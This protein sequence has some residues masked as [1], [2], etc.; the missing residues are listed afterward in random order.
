M[1]LHV[2]TDRYVGRDIT[3]CRGHSVPEDM[4]VL[5]NFGRKP[6]KSSSGSM[7]GTDKLTNIC[8]NPRKNANC[9]PFA[10]PQEAIAR[11]P[12]RPLI[13]RPVVRVRAGEPK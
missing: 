3:A 11:Y 6:P 13:T 9:G 4:S 5:V 2:Y 12:P 7:E 8:A 1:H 10:Q